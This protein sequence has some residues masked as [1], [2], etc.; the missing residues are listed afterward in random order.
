M[1]GVPHAARKPGSGDRIATTARPGP[2][3]V[4]AARGGA[5]CG[6]PRA[7]A[8]VLETA[9]INRAAART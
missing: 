9:D 2:A 3:T 6:T 5:A 8:T 1:R 7:A 4:A